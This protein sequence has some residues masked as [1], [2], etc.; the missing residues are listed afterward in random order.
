[1]SD[2]SRYKAVS[3]S[4]DSWI[5]TGLLIL[6]FWAPLP[7]GSNRTWAIGL[8]FSLTFILFISTG[9]VWLRRWNLA[10][11]RVSLFKWPLA[12]LLAMVSLTWLQTLPLPAAW[13]QAISPMAAQAQAPQTW[14]TLSLDVYQTR[15]MGVLA[16]TYFSAFWVVIM[17][18]RDANRLDGLA[19]VLVYSGVL[20]TVLGAVL[21][22]VQADYRI[23]Y[24]HVSHTQMIGTFVNRNSMA[25]YLC[26]CLSMGVGLMLSR[27][28]DNAGLAMTWKARVVNVI[29]FILSSKMRLRLLLIIMV[30][31]LVLTRSRMGNTAFFTALLVVGLVAIVLARNTAPKTIAL[32]ASLVIIDVLVIG[33]WVGLE[34]V[35][36]RI[37]NTELTVADGGASES[38]EARTKAARTALALVQDFVVAGSGGGSF[39]NLFLTY[40]TPDFGYSYVDH[41]H[42]DYVEIA[43]D[44]GVVGL[45]ILGLLVALTLWK[46]LTVLAK[47]RSTLPLGIAFGVAMSIVGL[48]VHSTVDFNLQIPSNAITIVI[49][50][51][52]GW[53]AYT[54]PPGAKVSRA[55]SRG[56]D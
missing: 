12:L 41:T 43:S 30:I 14:M 55:A 34:K 46:T 54:L 36:D 50:L 52:M 45:G 16:F 32:I 2:R 5:Y 17:T 35:V 51:A 11:Q 38:I 26:M 47:R 28:S 7:L 42:N 40:R 24:S 53:L 3:P 15:L 31:G 18:V 48:L 37:Q 23:F 22:S 21:L 20:Q 9:W 10:W 13:V 19:Q 49:I 56:D 39:Y 33:T 25:G 27:L 1:M 6:I 44:Y 29:A 8:L 4:A